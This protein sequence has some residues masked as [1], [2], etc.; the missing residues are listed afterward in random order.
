MRDFIKEQVAKHPLL[1]GLVLGASIGASLG[2]GSGIFLMG[3]IFI[4]K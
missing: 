1:S 3:L 4:C 2:L